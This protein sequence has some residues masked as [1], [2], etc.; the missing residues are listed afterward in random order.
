MVNFGI[1][2]GQCNMVR[3]L[4]RSSIF[5]QVFLVKPMHFSI[6]YPSQI[7]LSPIENRVSGTP[8]AFGAEMFLGPPAGV[9][10]AHGALHAGGGVGGG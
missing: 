8:Q 10:A 6:A 3:L 1:M 2:L 4:H 5:H 9:E 7:H